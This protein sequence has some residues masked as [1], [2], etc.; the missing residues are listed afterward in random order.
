MYDHKFPMFDCSFSKKDSIFPL[1]F[2]VE[3]LKVAVV[4]A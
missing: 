4:L 3:K 1:L 2:H